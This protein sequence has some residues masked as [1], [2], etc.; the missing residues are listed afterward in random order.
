MIIPHWA[1][2]FTRPRDTIGV[3]T[4]RSATNTCTPF[5]ASIFAVAS[6]N[7]SPPNRQSCPINAIGFLN[8]LVNQSAVA[9]EI[10]MI[11]SIVKSLAMT[12]RHPSVP[13]LILS[14]QKHYL[15]LGT[16]NLH[17]ILHDTEYFR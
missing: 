11:L 8:F 15:D 7:I 1:L 14:I 5:D 16:L 4:K 12:P 6:M 10:L 2:S 3:V 13:N 9:R 17:L